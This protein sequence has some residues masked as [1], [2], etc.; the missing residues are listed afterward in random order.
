MET[1]KLIIAETLYSN[2]NIPVKTHMKENNISL[3][4]YVIQQTIKMLR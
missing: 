3:V 1:P 2:T 4:I